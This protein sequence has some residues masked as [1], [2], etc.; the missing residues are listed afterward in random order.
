[1]AR[2][3]RK[4]KLSYKSRREMKRFAGTDSHDDIITVHRKVRIS[5][6][7]RIQPTVIAIMIDVE[8]VEIVT[9]HNYIECLPCHHPLNLPLP[10][11][12]YSL[13]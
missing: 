11:G 13:G 3:S 7:V 12:R 6:V 4:T 1:M 10:A 2:T 8:H 9:V 5:V